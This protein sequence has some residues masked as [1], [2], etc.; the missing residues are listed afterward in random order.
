MTA[1]CD[2][3]TSMF[4]A[5]NLRPG[6]D[7]STFKPA[8]EAFCTHLHE[9]GHLDA[10]RLW[11]RAAHEGYNAGFPDVSV[12]LELC[13]H[14]HQASLD[15]WDYIEGNTQPMRRLHHALIGQITDSIFILCHAR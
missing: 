14:D 9:V 8:F 6:R 1:P 5:F 4:G 10:W 11:E 13:F 12:M 15:A 2:A 3:T 7:L